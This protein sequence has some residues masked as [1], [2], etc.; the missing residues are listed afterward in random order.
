[1]HEGVA[2]K[3]ANQTD[4]KIYVV[5]SDYQSDYHGP[6]AYTIG[7]RVDTAGKLPEG[8]VSRNVLAG[9]Y[10]VVTT[11]KGPVW[12]VVP[13]AWRQIWGLED[14]N[15]LGGVRAYR[16]DFEVYDERARDP[17]NSQVDVYLGLK[18]R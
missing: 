14:K 11:P 18:A 3:I 6:Y 13:Q 9:D 4:D 15:Q 7:V 17:Q 1:M 10:A 5:Y 12:Q 2:A 8:L 16:S